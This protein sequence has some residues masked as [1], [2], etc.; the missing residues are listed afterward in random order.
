MLLLM[1]LYTNLIQWQYNN[2]TTI[3]HMIQTPIHQFVNIYP[4]ANVSRDAV[5]KE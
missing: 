5:G 3:T 4:A 1:A 2:P